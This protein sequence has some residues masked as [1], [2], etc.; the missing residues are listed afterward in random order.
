MK[1]SNCSTIRYLDTW[2]VWEF[3]L[4]F[5]LVLVLVCGWFYPLTSVTSRPCRLSDIF[6]YSGIARLFRDLHP[7]LIHAMTFMWPWLIHRPPGQCCST[8]VV[9]NTWICII[10]ITHIDFNQFIV[11]TLVLIF[12]RHIRGRNVSL[13]WLPWRLVTMETGYHGDWLSWLDCKSGTMQY[14]HVLEDGDFTVEMSVHH[15]LI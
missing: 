6:C 9:V 5:D 3:D 7:P 8:Q 4:V 12:W 15:V 10:T 13:S 11:S 14:D 1:L 2:K